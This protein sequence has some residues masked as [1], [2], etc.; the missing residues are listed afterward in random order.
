MNAV[1]TSLNDKS[2]YTLATPVR[3]LRWLRGTLGTIILVLLAIVTP[4]IPASAAAGTDR[5]TANEVLGSGST[6]ASGA[7]SLVMQ[8]DGNL[9]LYAS[10]G[11]PIWDSRTFGHPG[12]YA[13]MQADGNLVI[14]QTQ[15]SIRVA[16]WASGT[17]GRGVSTLIVQSD[18]NAVT[19]SPAGATWATNTNKQAYAVNRFPSYRWG[20][21]QWPCLRSLWIRESNWNE[22]A[23]NGSSGAY[24]IPQALPAPKMASEGSDY[25]TNPNTQIRWGENYISGGY[26]TPCGAWDHETRRG[27]Y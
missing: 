4:Q 20:A 18:G 26:G 17:A 10:Q 13:V 15:G 9:V 27:W 5:L 23:Q 11:V 3:T 2:C 7:A 16:I 19:Y 21:E 14:Y 8:G 6:I 1:P 12:A 22:L 25:R 24:G